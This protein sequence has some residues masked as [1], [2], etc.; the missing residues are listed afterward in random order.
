MPKVGGGRIAAIEILKTNLRVKEC[1]TLGES[2]GKTF[3]DIIEAG[4]AFGMQTF[5]KAI[6]RIMRLALSLKIPHWLMHREGRWSAGASICS[7]L[8]KARELRY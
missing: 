3:Y 6:I 1:V 7:R 5:D 2:E 4:E 8:H